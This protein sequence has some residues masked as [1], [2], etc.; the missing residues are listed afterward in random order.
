VIRLAALVALVALLAGCGS[1]SDDGSAAATSTT[2]SAPVEAPTTIRDRLGAELGDDA[3]AGEVLDSLG[4]DLRGQLDA[5]V[6]DDVATSPLLAYR[7][8]PIPAA[9]V[10]ALV[11][12]AF[13]YR[14]VAG[15]SR[16]PGP[17]NEALA[18]AVE[19][20]V[21]DRP[22][23]VYA[24]TE[25]AKLLVAD[26][27]DQVTS[28]APDVDADGNLVY[29][30]TAGVAAKVKAAAG[31]EPTFGVLGFADHAVRC[32]LTTEAA[33]LHGGVP[34]GVTL[35]ATYDPESGQPWTRD[36]AS[37]LKTDLIGRLTTL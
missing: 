19:R 3:L 8:T 25:I 9:D 34:E 14:D 16:L 18:T 17:V 28:I 30:S 10:D 26:G 27:A 15:G 23:P 35:P 29:L 21:A 12:Y 24:Q 7:P 22:V 31:T 11:V 32:V 1:G 6:G 37:Y 36:R 4:A 2:T 20:F 5:A 33:G 13:G